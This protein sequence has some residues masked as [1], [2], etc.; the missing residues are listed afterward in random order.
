M[1]E[2]NLKEINSVAG[3]GA[4]ANEYAPYVTAAISFFDPSDLSAA[5]K[6]GVGFAGIV[7]AAELTAFASSIMMGVVAGSFISATASAAMN[8][9]NAEGYKFFAKK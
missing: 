3:A 6:F 8:Y 5:Q 1:K 9:Y 2:L 4:N 7:A